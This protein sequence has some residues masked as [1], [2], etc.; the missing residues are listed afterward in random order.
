[1]TDVT[2][3]TPEP[4]ERLN[5]DLRL[6]A[7]TLSDAEAR[8]LVDI[9]YQMQDSRIRS[10]NQVRAQSESGEPHDIL[11]WFMDQSSTMELQIKGALH[12]YAE[13]HQIGL[14]ALATVG[15]GPVIAAGI[16]ARIDIHQA[17]T[18]GHIWRFAGL[19]P[20]QKWEKGKKRPWN[21][22]LKRIC[23][24]LGE[25]FVKVSGNPKAFYG[26]IY[27]ARKAR[28]V[29]MNEA[30]AF[31]DLAA[32]K[33]KRVGKSTEAWKHYSKGR[34]PPAHI[35]SRAK[36]YA[37]KLWLA[38]LHQVWFEKATGAPAPLPYPIAHL[39]HAHRIEPPH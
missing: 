5:R 14:W 30:G 38:H 18:V 24:L 23:W 20:T 2:T 26:H 22:D 1:M 31:A 8:F 37:V 33:L 11:L 36:R 29:E 9:Y 28:E 7:R 27:A 6:A 35:H 21:A 34:L 10:K 3:Q 12:K 16:I 39:D 15:V 4:I 32:E 25:S 13:A 19:D 17:P